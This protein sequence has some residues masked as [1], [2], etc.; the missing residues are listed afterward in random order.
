MIHSPMLQ[1]RTLASGSKGNATF[2]ASDTTSILVDV[3]LCLP[4][5]VKRMN[6]A[7][8]D[9]ATIDA[10]LLTHE[11]S[12]HTVGL[13]SFIKK[14][15]S[16]VHV[17][18]VAVDIFASV[19]REQISTFGNCFQIG[20]ITVDF[21]PLPHDSKF[22]FGYTFRKDDAKISIATDL[23]RTTPDMIA[24]MAGSQIVLIESNHD[25]GKLSRNTKYPSWLKRRVS[26]SSGHLSNTAASL[27]VLELA[28]QNVQQVVLVHLS[29][30]NNSPNLAY[31]VIRDFLATKG[32]EEGVDISIDV[33]AQHEIGL[34]FQVD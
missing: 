10:V 8:I 11:H 25:L 14:F 23:G 5:L 21:F 27:A 32:I 29:E 22:C 28:K 26:G 7:G 13:S 33:A 6:A 4:A 2:I 16:T 24:K 3:G 30:E 12:D 9:P 31:T 15:R 1:I 17:H 34:L 19:P 20:D 18:E